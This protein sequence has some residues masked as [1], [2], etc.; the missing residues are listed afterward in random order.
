MSPEPYLDLHQ[1]K[2]LRPESARTPLYIN[3]HLNLKVSLS[4]RW[5]MAVSLY[6]ELQ[7][8]LLRFI[9]PGQTIAASYKRMLL[10]IVQTRI[11]PI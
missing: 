10:L 3:K 2:S 11:F 9:K 7:I 5:L 6:I 1:S 4:E 8:A